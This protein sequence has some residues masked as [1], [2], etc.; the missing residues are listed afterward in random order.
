MRSKEAL[1]VWEELRIEE[2]ENSGQVDFCV[3]DTGMVSGNRGRAQGEQQKSGKRFKAERG[4]AQEFRLGRRKAVAGAVGIV[5]VAA[6]FQLPARRVK[7]TKAAQA[8]FLQAELQRGGQHSQPVL[9]AAAEVDGRGFG[10]VL[11]GTRNFADVETEIHALGQHLVV[12]N[13]VIG[14]FQQR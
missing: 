14:I 6:G 7:D 12:E 8:S 1:V 10:K 13:K 2:L 11:G 3:L 5:I 4:F 9:H